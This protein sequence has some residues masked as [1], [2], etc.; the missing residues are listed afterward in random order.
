MKFKFLL[1]TSRYDIM[2]FK[3]THIL[4]IDK[5]IGQSILFINV[6]DY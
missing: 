5:S 4:I 3:F 1:T 6:Y 2:M